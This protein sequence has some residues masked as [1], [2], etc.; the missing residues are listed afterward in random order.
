LILLALGLG[1]AVWARRHLSTYWSG[2]ITIKSEH[3]LIRTG[4]Y[5]RVRH[6]IYSGFIV[7]M[8]GTALALGELRGFLAV[9]ILIIAYCRK[10]QIEE[11][12]LLQR[13]G[14]EYR[15]YQRAVKALLPFVL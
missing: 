8:V 6:P 3:R 7:G 1:V 2:T 12:W 4:P 15:R 5:A 10:I 13:F 11:A 9:L 14:E